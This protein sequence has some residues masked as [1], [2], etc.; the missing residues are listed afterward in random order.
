MAGFLGMS[1][2]ME[3]VLEDELVAGIWKKS[4]FLPSLLWIA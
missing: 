2:M 4:H 3:G 1:K